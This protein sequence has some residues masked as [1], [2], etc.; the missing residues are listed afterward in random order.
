MRRDLN[1]RQT[2]K[3]SILSA[4]HWFTARFLGLSHPVQAD[5]EDGLMT[6]MPQF[7]LRQIGWTVLSIAGALTTAN[8]EK[9]VE[10]GPSHS[11]PAMWRGLLTN[12]PPAS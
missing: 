10:A 12:W 2:L 7:F 8:Y 9:M 1:E 6:K 4:M 5:F 3:K 11:V